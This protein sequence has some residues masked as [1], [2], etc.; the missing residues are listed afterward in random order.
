MSR[1]DT[2]IA[3]LYALP[4]GEFTAARNAL[5]KELKKEDKE[6]AE[7]IQ[8]LAKPPA[9][10]WAVNALFQE[11]KAAM[12]ELLA[13]GRKARQALQGVL[14]EGDPEELRGALREQRKL[15]DQLLRRAVELLKKAKQPAGPAIAERIG[16]NLESLALS[17]DAAAIAE[18]GWLDGDLDPPGFEV[19][20]GLQLGAARPERPNLRSAPEPRSVQPAPEP[21]K[22]TEKDER[23][24][25]EE[26]RARERV[27]RAEEKA[28]AA[29]EEA[30]R[31]RHEA[32]QAERAA[33]EAEKAAEKAR[34]RAET[35]GEAAER[36]EAGAE[37]AREELAKVERK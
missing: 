18:R 5:A 30:A 23:K 16:T 20:A 13:S 3:R 10:A 29:R 33:E 4:L 9:S 19:L 7:R 8:E 36:A 37:R 12:A 2:E 25:R 14:T 35:A 11:E 21:K 22:K 15:R 26:A 24:E 28:A 34:R 1:L 32:R 17:P 6:A 31:L 27:A